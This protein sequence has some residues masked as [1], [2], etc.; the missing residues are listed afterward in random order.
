MGSP[1]GFVGKSLARGYVRRASTKDDRSRGWPGRKN[2]AFNPLDAKREKL[3]RFRLGETVRAIIVAFRSRER[4]AY[5]AK[6][7]PLRSERRQWCTATAGIDD[8]K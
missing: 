4:T 7:H 3:A 5:F 6:K 8:E 2:W 1:L